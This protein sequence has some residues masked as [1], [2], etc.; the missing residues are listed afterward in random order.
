MLRI[1][2]GCYQSFLLDGPNRHDVATDFVVEGPTQRWVWH[3][4][5]DEVER[6]EENERGRDR[7]AR[8]F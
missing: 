2:N 4:Q 6:R 7:T 1:R 5:R 3:K 8:A